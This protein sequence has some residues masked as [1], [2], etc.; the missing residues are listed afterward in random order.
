[1]GGTDDPRLAVRTATVVANAELFQPQHADAAAGE[2]ETGRRAHAADA[3]DD[4]IVLRRAHGD[5][6]CD[7]PAEVW[8]W[9]MRQPSGFFSTIDVNHRSSVSAVISTFHRPRTSIFDSDTGSA[10]SSVKLSFP[11]S[12][13]SAW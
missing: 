5:F 9:T 10:V 6:F 11:I 2:L 3:N 13:P 1:V 4:H 7:S 8:S 12:R